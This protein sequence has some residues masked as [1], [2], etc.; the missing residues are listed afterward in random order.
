MRIFHCIVFEFLS[1]PCL[2]VNRKLFKMIFFVFSSIKFGRNIMIYISFSKWLLFFFNMISF[3]IKLLSKESICNLFRVWITQIIF[4]CI[5][6]IVFIFW[7][8]L[9]NH[10]K[11][12][13]NVNYLI[14]IFNQLLYFFVVQNKLEIFQVLILFIL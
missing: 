3:I 6:S 4:W 12:L 5:C 1:K 10:L 11:I 13:F 2:F 8:I 7:L 14:Q 9:N